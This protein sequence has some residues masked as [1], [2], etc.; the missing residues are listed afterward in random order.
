MTFD[1]YYQNALQSGLQ[2]TEENRNLCKTTWDAAITAAVAAC[3]KS[4]NLIPI[5]EARPAISQL[6][7][8]FS[9]SDS[10]LKP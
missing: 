5:H 9:E 4:A 1:Y 2:D 10:P 7:T 6:H 8:W 3:Y